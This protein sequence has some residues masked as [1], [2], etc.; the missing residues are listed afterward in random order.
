MLLLAKARLASKLAKA[1]YKVT[2]YP[3]EVKLEGLLD[4]KGEWDYRTDLPKWLV[5]DFSQRP[6]FRAKADAPMLHDE[7][8]AALFPSDFV[9]RAE[10]TMNNMHL[11]LTDDAWREFLPR[12][13]GEVSQPNNFEA[14]AFLIDL[15]RPTK[16]DSWTELRAESYIDTI[17][18]AT[19]H[20]I[21]DFRTNFS[22]V[23]SLTRSDCIDLLSDQTTSAALKSVFE[24]LG[25][26]T[27]VLPEREELIVTQLHARVLLGLLLS[28]VPLNSKDRLT[29]RLPLHGR[30]RV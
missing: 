19:G 14:S 9:Q 29:R 17:E 12:D 13:D 24:I 25:Q 20:G 18:A 21:I 3:V 16:V 23:H 1:A 5:D 2:P 7:L 4:I 27:Q 8:V 11:K 15:R 10:F 22:K 6:G 28:V 26:G 30:L